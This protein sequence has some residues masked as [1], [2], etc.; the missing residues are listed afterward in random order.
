VLTLSIHSHPNDAY[1]F[2]S[3]FADE[4]G[5]GAGAGFNKNFPLDGHADEAAYMAAIGKAVRRIGQFR[6]HFLVLSLGL[7]ILK[8]DPTGTFSLPVSTMRRIGRQLAELGLPML[9]VQEGGYNL[10]NLKRGPAE[11]FA[12]IAEAIVR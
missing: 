10:S 9:V 8:G 6:P 1:P 7:D 2:F 3:G 4:T 11:L 5:E 12:G